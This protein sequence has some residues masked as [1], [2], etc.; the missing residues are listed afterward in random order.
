M[1]KTRT[2]AGL[3]P[4]PPRLRRVRGVEATDHRAFT[5][6]KRRAI[7]SLTL[8]AALAMAAVTGCQ[9]AP[10]FAWWKHEKAPDDAS[11][12]ARSATPALPSAQS[13]PQPVAVA[14]LTPAAPPSSTNLAATAGSTPAGTTGATVASTAAAPWAPPVSIPVTSPSTL[15]TAP[16][17]DDSAQ[18]ALADKL[19]STP[20][21]MSP[22][23]SANVGAIA[24]AGPYDPNAYKPMAASVSPNPDHGNADNADRY[25][26]GPAGPS[27]AYT[28]ANSQPLASTPAD[29]RYGSPR[30]SAAPPAMPGTTPLTDPSAVAVD[31][32]S[33]PTL[34]TL[35]EKTAQFAIS[36]T[37]G[38]NASA[39]STTTA[40]ASTV[41]LA[42][43]PGQYRPG[44]T[45]TYMNASTTSPIEVAS[46]PTPPAAT[47]ATVP[48]AAG[49]V[50]QPWA[51]STPA[52]PTTGT[53]T[54]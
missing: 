14:G 51:P 26:A 52:T 22:A 32:Y 30:S 42:S 18:N 10:R 37:P 44:R 8:V 38:A 2:V 28:V 29:D 43:A 1:P 16:T 5:A 33:N 47:N 50:S 24:A 19:V 20:S 54:Y 23:T 41:K 15:A 48:P 13:T 46:R 12:V 6:M 25:A 7:R 53:R 21:T 35:P 3:Q 39:A 4:E 27:T 36:P 17:A 45:S 49:G 31:R 40:G 11:V 34:P 9:S